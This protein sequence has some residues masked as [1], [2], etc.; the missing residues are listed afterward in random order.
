MALFESFTPA[1]FDSIRLIAVISG[2]AAAAFT[3]LFVISRDKFYRMLQSMIDWLNGVKALVPDT[4]TFFQALKGS[5]PEKL[6]LI[7]VICLIILGAVLRAVLSTLPIGHDEAYTFMVFAQRDLGSIISDYHLPN[8]HVFHTILVH[9]TTQLFGPRLWAIRLP[10][11]LSILSMIPVSYLISANYFNR[12][13]ALLISTAVAIMPNFILVSLNAR[14]YPVAAFFFLLIWLLAIYLKKHMNL[15]AWLLFI[16]FS[17]LGFFTLPLM[18]YGFGMVLGWMF[19]SWL[20]ADISSDYPRGV[21]LRNLIL[22]GLVVVALTLLLYAPIILNNDARSTA[23]PPYRAADES[24]FP[25]LA[26]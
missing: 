6:D 24:G 14:G 22:S 13:T 23:Q 9:Y 16:I 19:V 3:A 5:I 8:N 17:T 15:F 26:L 25:Q 7:F 4:K 18:L 20:L 21:F 1:V 12:K 2:L 10:A 11:T